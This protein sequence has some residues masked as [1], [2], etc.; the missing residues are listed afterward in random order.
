MT[1]SQVRQNRIAELRALP[2][3]YHY[4]SELADALERIELLER[5]AQDA[6]HKLN[7]IRTNLEETLWPS[8]RMDHPP[9]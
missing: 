7:L 1:T 6:A 2:Q 9:L 8:I 5:A 4:A 3:Q